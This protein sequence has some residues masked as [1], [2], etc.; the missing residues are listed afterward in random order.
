[1]RIPAH[2]AV[3]AAAIQR[4]FRAKVLPASHGKLTYFI[5]QPW[6]MAMQRCPAQTISVI[7]YAAQAR[8]NFSQYVAV[9]LRGIFSI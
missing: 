3:V 8:W 7:R 6:P 1:M 2:R 4:Y 5:Y 9:F